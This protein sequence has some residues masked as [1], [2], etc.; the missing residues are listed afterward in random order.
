MTA[1]LL[2]RSLPQLLALALLALACQPLL[3]QDKS[4]KPSLQ[5]AD[6]ALLQKLLQRVETLEA[7]LNQR[8]AASEATIRAR[9]TEAMGNVRTIAGETASA[10][11][12]RLTGQ[13]PDQASLNR[14]LDATSA[15]H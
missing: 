9:T 14:A 1:T 8:L 12:E 11:V 3:G 7:E 5:Q 13:A 4:A 15:V 6:R 2:R 10:I